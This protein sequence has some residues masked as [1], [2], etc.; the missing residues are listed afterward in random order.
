MVQGGIDAV[1]TNGV[2]AKLL[3]VRDVSAA[4]I[5]IGERV[6]EVAGLREGS[7]VRRRVAKMAVKQQES[8]VNPKNEVIASA[9][10][11]YGSEL[12]MSPCSW[13]AR[14]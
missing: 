5:C 10:K 13:Y 9:G 3:H 4:A 11:A 7:S 1:D 12:V 6:H 2:D 14:P 8:Q